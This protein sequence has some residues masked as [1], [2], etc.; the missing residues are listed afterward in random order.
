MARQETLLDRT[1]RLL[2]KHRATKSLREIAEASGI[3]REYLKAL[4]AGR[5]ADPGILKIQK[6][7]DWLDLYERANAM[8]GSTPGTSPQQSAPAA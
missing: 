7:H 6:L 4:V 3:D 8:G 1:M 5:I 2:K